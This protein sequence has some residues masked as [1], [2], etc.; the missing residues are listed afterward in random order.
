MAHIYLIRHG[1]ASMGLENYDQLSEVGIEQAKYLAKVFRDRNLNFSSVVSGTMK[2]QNDTALYSLPEEKFK[3]IITDSAW[4]E[5]DHEDILQKYEPR[6]RDK[7]QLMQDVMNTENPKQK[8]QYIL[9]GA[10]ARWITNEGND[11]KE[12]YTAF[13]ARVKTGLDTLKENLQRDDA[14]AVYTSGGAIAITL[15]YILGLDD[16]KTFE[17]QFYIANASIT[18]LKVN[19][20]GTHLL[21]FNDHV[22]FDKK[23]VTFR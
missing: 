5:F 2:R 14:I 4:N 15:K 6:Y 23:L 16:R 22:F 1:Q 13:S 17:L 18:T 11:Y 20:R 3:N 8:I 10:L 7:M 21:T 9:E 19:P 12:S